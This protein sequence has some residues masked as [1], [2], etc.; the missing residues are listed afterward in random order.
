[1]K[2]K[3]SL[4]LKYKLSE[5]AIVGENVILLDQLTL[6]DRV[7]SPDATNL[8]VRLAIALMRDTQGKID[9]DLPVRGNLDD[10]EFSWGHLVFQA[11]INLVTKAVTSPFA[12]LGSLVGGDGEEL[13]FVEFEYGSESFLPQQ[14]QKLDKLAQALQERPALQLQ[15]EGAADSEY[16]RL[17]LAE[18][19][20][21]AE[22]RFRRFEEMQVSGEQ[23]TVKPEEMTLTE[24]EFTRLLTEKYV[25]TYGHDPFTTIEE[26]GTEE[27]AI[28]TERSEEVP[29]PPEVD[30]A[31]RMAMAKQRLIKE[32]IIDEIALQRLAQG[33]ATQIKGYL[34][35]QGEI[36]ADRLFALEPKIGE[37]DVS[38]GEAI[39]VNLTLSGT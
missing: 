36:S 26:K 1:E 6:G 25:E 30:P 14:A 20:L 22:L 5:N 29:G 28:S 9:I 19:M 27:G 23:A 32:M 34:I 8:P 18:E 17:S 33:R 4:D 24:E 16:D 10:P 12:L 38:D 31:V 2:G 7:E 21:M 39:R 35:E 3:L 37:Q 11:L 13:S 15:I